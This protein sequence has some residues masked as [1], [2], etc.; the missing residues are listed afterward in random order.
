MENAAFESTYPRVLTS[1]TRQLAL[2]HVPD[3][4]CRLHAP[5]TTPPRRAKDGPRSAIAII[6]NPFPVHA[7]S[8][9][10]SSL[11]VLAQLV[12]EIDAAGEPRPV[13][14]NHTRRLMVRPRRRPCGP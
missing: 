14:D 10:A 6:G 9:V 13:C 2:Q 3:A 12:L 7:T 5:R 8:D 1:T 11:H 4:T